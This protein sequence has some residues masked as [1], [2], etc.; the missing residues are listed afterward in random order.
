MRDGR[1]SEEAVGTQLHALGVA[2]E[3]SP[4]EG[5]HLGLRGPVRTVK[6]P[7]NKEIEVKPTPRSE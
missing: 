3:D 5:N 4:Q 7:P 2:K 6:T 1:Q